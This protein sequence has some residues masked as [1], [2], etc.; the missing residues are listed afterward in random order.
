MGQPKVATL[1]D[2]SIRINQCPKCGK[3]FS[4]WRILYQHRRSVH[5]KETRQQH[6]ECGT[7]FCGRSGSHRHLRTAH[8]KAQSHVRGQCRKCFTGLGNFRKHV[9]NNQA[10]INAA[11]VLTNYFSWGLPFPVGGKFRPVKQ[12]SQFGQ[13]SAKRTLVKAIRRSEQTKTPERTSRVFRMPHNSLHCGQLTDIKICTCTQT[14]LVD[15]TCLQETSRTSATTR[16]EKV[17][18]PNGEHAFQAGIPCFSTGDLF[19]DRSR[20]STVAK[21]DRVLP[22]T[23]L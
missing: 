15:L 11:C 9:E 22:K 4:S 7:L 6:D 10:V 5:P 1:N 21:L 13:A 8:A 2:L 16:A 3:F 23:E 18:V 20:A 14:V 12:P 17:L 19:T